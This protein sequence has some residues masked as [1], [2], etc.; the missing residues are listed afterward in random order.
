VADPTRPLALLHGQPRPTTLRCTVQI[1]HL[2]GLPDARAVSMVSAAVLPFL[3]RVLCCGGVEP[4]RPGCPNVAAG[5]NAAGQPTILVAVIAASASAGDYVCSLIHAAPMLA[6]MPAAGPARRAVAL[7]AW[8]S[9]GGARRLCSKWR[10]VF[11]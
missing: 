4:R 1:R 10:A 8:P 7:A 6:W 3:S 11:R 5:G 2:P 9:A